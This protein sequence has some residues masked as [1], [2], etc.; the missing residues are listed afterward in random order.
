MLNRLVRV[1]SKHR[2]ITVVIAEAPKKAPKAVTVLLA[3]W[4]IY[5]LTQLIGLLL[6]GKQFD[7]RVESPVPIT[8][9]VSTPLDASNP[10]NLQRL[11]ALNLFADTGNP[12]GGFAVREYE[13]VANKTQLNLRLE[14]IIDAEPASSARAIIVHNGKQDHY[15]IGDRLPS[16][17][18]VMLADIFVDRI[19]IDNNGQLESLWLYAK[20]SPGKPEATNAR[21]QSTVGQN[22][23]NVRDLRHNVDVSAMVNQYRQQLYR[24]PASL[25]E[26]LQIMPAKVNGKLI[27]YRLKPGRDRKQFEQIGFKPNDIVTRINEFSLHEPA[28]L[29]KLYLLMR[30]ANEARF[31]LL[32]GDETIELWVSIQ[33]DNS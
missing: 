18:R 27:G 31:S 20:N 15:H 1:A 4:L 26:V 28:T 25:A 9:S 32:R 14:G 30:K 17:S 7:I 8:D 11:Q 29:P 10:I 3:S 19:I 2:F 21:M 33:S 23:T 13:V 16:T 22:Q 6:P 5:N 12:M 24:N